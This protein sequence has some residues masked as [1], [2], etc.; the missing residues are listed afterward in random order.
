[1]TEL[2]HH[3]AGWWRC[4]FTVLVGGINVS[5]HRLVALFVL[6]TRRWFWVLDI[7]GDDSGSLIYQVMVLVRR[8]TR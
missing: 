4:F 1:M 3:C 6:Y 2:V 7:P 5:V 8:Y